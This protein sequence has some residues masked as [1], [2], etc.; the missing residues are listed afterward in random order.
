L[1]AEECPRHEHALDVHALSWRELQ[2]VAAKL[3]G[4]IDAERAVVANAKV[5]N[6]DGTAD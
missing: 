5:V 4:D 2:I 1:A 6:G 3:V